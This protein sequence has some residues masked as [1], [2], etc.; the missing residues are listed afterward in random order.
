MIVK[1]QNIGGAL[2]LRGFTTGGTYM[3]PGTKLERDQLLTMHVNNRQSLIDNGFIDIYPP[4]H[5][6]DLHMVS[7]GFG[8]YDV[9]QGIKLNIDPLT[10]EQAEALMPAHSDIPVED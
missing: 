7:R 2:V 3:R 8:K 4:L 9:Y 10:R 6:I 5:G 1:E